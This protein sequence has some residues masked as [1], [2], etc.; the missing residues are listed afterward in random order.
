MKTLIPAAIRCSLMFTA[1]AALSLAYPASVQAVPT[2]YQY[3]GNPF[4][5]FE[6]G[7]YTTNDFVTAM[8]T[9]AAPLPPNSDVTVHPTAFTLADGVQTLTNTTPFIAS[10]FH[11]QTNAS[12]EI[13]DWHVDVSAPAHIN[14][15]NTDPILDGVRS[16]GHGGAASFDPGEWTQ[17]IATPDA[18]STLSLMTLTLMALG[19]VAR[20]FQRAAG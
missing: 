11:F 14:F 15:I 13:T 5:F 12:A 7:D 3:R 4:T 16:E 9:L 18:G 10:F 6:P 20:R 17:A 1:V 8:V 19:L 2:T